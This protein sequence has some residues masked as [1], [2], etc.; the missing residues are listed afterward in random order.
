MSKINNIPLY[1]YREEW[2]R[3][4][5]SGGKRDISLG[6]YDAMLKLVARAARVYDRDIVKSM[7]L[8]FFD[9]EEIKS[10]EKI[11]KVK[12][13]EYTSDLDFLVDDVRDFDNMITSEEAFESLEKEL[14]FV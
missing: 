12:E 7:G 11:E 14:G 10:T 1:N 8:K 3:G 13:I 6:E 5:A 9:Q 2:Q 4:R